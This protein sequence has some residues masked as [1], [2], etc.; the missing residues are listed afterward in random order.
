MAACS[1]S[2]PQRPS[3]EDAGSRRAEEARAGEQGTQSSLPTGPCAHPG[4]G[5]GPG[6]STLAC[7]ERERSRRSHP[8]IQPGLYSWLRCALKRCFIPGCCHRLLAGLA[9]ACNSREEFGI[10]K[11]QNTTP[12]RGR[13]EP[14]TSVP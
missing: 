5:C 11:K 4:S 14:E 7:P 6:P 13:Q 8:W 9:L 10:K 1:A 12:N 2:Q 3:T